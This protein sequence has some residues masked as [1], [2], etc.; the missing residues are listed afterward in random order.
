MSDHTRQSI[1]VLDLRQYKSNARKSRYYATKIT[2]EARS[3][4]IW[5]ASLCKRD[6]S[7]G[8]IS[9]DTNTTTHSICLEQ[10]RQ[11]EPHH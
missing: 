2:S 10:L 5:A 9:I 7:R 6:Q 11:T 8:N 4:S 1:D 3:T